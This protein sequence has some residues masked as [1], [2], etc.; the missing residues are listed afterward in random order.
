MLGCW[1]WCIRV[2]M[3]KGGFTWTH[4]LLSLHHSFALF[5]LR[6]WYAAFQLHL[7][8]PRE[9]NGA[10]VTHVILEETLQ[11]PSPIDR[12]PSR[13]DNNH[14]HPKIFHLSFHIQPH[15]FPGTQ[16]FQRCIHSLLCSLPQPMYCFAEPKSPCWRL[17]LAH[18]SHALHGV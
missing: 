9:G 3:A 12:L 11:C 17:D 2:L 6:T 18:H 15:A 8:T 4:E 7:V 16:L 10:A 14:C 5:M 1:V 13:T